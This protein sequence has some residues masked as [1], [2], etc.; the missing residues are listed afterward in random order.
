MAVVVV[1]GAAVGTVTTTGIG[2]ALTETEDASSSRGR[3]R[4]CREVVS[5]G[6]GGTM[7][8]PLLLFFLPLPRGVLVT[9]K[10]DS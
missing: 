4:R 7:P 3:R 6:T 10:R 8:S 2:G 9:E 1:V 5:A